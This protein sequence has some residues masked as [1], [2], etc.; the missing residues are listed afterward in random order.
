[1]SVVVLQGDGSQL[2]QFQATIVLVI[3]PKDVS[4]YYRD[5]CSAMFIAAI[6]DMSRNWKQP[7]CHSTEEL[8]LKNVA[9][10]CNELLLSRLR[11]NGIMKFAGEWMELEKKNHP[12]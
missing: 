2:S 10:L 5:T 12:E 4:S 1:M 11:K 7:R 3:Q 8:V 9:L 6:F